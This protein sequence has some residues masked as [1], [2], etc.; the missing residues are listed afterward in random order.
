ML[1][2]ETLAAGNR[3][4]DLGRIVASVESADATSTEASRQLNLTQCKVG[5]TIELCTRQGLLSGALYAV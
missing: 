4:T 3:G 1:P 5:G 2:F